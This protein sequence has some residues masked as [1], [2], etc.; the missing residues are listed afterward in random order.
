MSAAQKI[1]VGYV[2]ASR[3]HPAVPQHAALDA[4]KANK[5]YVEGE[6]GMR[7]LLRAVVGREYTILVHT[8]GRLGR[9]RDEL[10]DVMLAILAEGSTIRELSSGRE[11]TTK[12]EAA[13]AAMSLE[14]AA[15]LAGDARAP[16]SKE[17]RRRGKMGGEAKS[18]IDREKL[19]QD[20]MPVKQARAIWTRPGLMTNGD[21]ITLMT[22]WTEWQAYRELGS[23]GVAIGRPKRK[24]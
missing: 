17:A 16:S 12:R 10:R 8:F 21:R 4:A 13:A 24:T 9:T 11:I 6:V 18:A 2:R 22:G 1:K 20:R 3:L 5:R 15:E 19:L 14:A 23:R 7:E